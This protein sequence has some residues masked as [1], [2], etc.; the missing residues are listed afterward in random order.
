VDDPD[1]ASAKAELRE[2]LL[3]ARHAMTDGERAA[4]RAAVRAVLLE[5]VS[6]GCVAGYEP[7]RTEPGSVELLAALVA[8]DVRVLV[9]ITRPDRDLEWATWTPG[10]RGPSLGLAAIGEAGLVLVPA[11]A[12][13][14]ADGTRLGRG[15]GSYDRALGRV[16]AGTPVVA[17]L[18][19]GELRAELPRGPLD[20]PVTAAVT[21]S[22]WTSLPHNPAGNVDFPSGR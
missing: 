6:T 5:R 3:A 19:D 4:A 22:G 7:L 15:G 8:R 11:L 14:R 12:A 10:G 2:E 16:P 20:V 1:L 21:P 13:A 17:L 9:P 18:F